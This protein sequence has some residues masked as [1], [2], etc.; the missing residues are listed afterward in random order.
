MNVSA[1][2]AIVGGSDGV[3]VGDGASVGADVGVSATVGGTVGRTSSVWRGTSVIFGV[4]VIRT[5]MISVVRQADKISIRTI[6]KIKVR[7]LYVLI[8]KSYHIA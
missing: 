4:G 7:Y 1:V 6:V 2:G 5:M 3:W 8:E